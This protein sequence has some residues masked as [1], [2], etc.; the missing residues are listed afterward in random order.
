VGMDLHDSGF[1][2]RGG[3]VLCRQ[4]GNLH[5]SSAPAHHAA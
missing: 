3:G 4:P 5:V 1:R 2:I